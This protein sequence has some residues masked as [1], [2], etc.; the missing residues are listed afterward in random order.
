[1]G[2]ITNCL[3]KYGWIINL[4]FLGGYAAYIGELGV[5]DSGILIETIQKTKSILRIEIFFLSLLIHLF[6][7]K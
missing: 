3:E 5:E 6:F 1:M 2:N 4:A 7:L